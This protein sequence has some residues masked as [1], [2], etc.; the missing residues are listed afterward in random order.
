[1]AADPIHS[2]LRFGFTRLKRFCLEMADSPSPGD[3]HLVP[4]IFRAGLFE[5]DKCSKR[6][7]RNGGATVDGR[8]LSSTRTKEESL[9]THYGYGDGKSG[10]GGYDMLAEASAGATTGLFADLIRKQL[11]HV[12]PSQATPLAGRVVPFRLTV[13]N[14]SIANTTVATVSAS[15]GAYVLSAN[16]GTVTS[17]QL[18]WSFSL[19]AGQSKSIDLW[20]QLPQTG[21]PVTLTAVLSASAGSYTANPV[22]VTYSLTPATRPDLDQAIADL[23]AYVANQ[24]PASVVSAIIDPI[25]GRKTPAAK[26]LDDLKAAKQDLI[27]GNV[28]RALQELVEATDLLINDGSHSLKPIRLMV[29]EAIYQTQK[30]Q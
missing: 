5:P 3:T 1:M 16:G 9:V 13:T 24:H 14:T 26:A 30:L 25:L 2:G 19:A 4:P 12:N 18:S 10:Y 23:T 6:V 29:D 20:V 7:L 17:G 11:D 28:Q 15:P 27:S 8:V 22:T 21:T